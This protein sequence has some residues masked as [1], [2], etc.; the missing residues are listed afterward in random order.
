MV[1]AATAHDGACFRSHPHAHAPDATVGFSTTSSGRSKPSGHVAPSS[2]SA[3]SWKSGGSDSQLVALQPST[4]V[5]SI[6]PRPVSSPPT[7]LPASTSAP[8]DPLAS[9]AASGASTLR[10]PTPVKALH[11]TTAVASEPRKMA[12]ESGLPIPHR[13]AEVGRS[14]AGF[15]PAPRTHEGLVR[16]ARA[17]QARR[18]SRP[19]RRRTTAK[20]NTP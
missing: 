16:S 15:A 11:A 12:R 10:S 4:T 17:G 2:P 1:P 9:D 20:R 3:T 8:G 5:A 18:W 19:V 13:V 6:G 14:A 7:S